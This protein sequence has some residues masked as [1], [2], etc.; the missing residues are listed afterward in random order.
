MGSIPIGLAVLVGTPAL[1]I[2]LLLLIEW[3]VIREPKPRRRS[4]SAR[5][6]NRISIDHRSIRFH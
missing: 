1:A 5:S 3:T 6:A 2:G 4:P